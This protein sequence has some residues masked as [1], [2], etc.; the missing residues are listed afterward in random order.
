MEPQ[1]GSSRVPPRGP[2]TAV[3]IAEPDEP[4]PSLFERL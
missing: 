2:R 3:G 1:A 4:V